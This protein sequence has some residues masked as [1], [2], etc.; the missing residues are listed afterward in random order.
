MENLNIN[1][2]ISNPGAER[3]ILSNCMNDSNILIECQSEGLTPKHFAIEANKIIYN[4]IVFLYTKGATIDALSILNIIKDEKTKAIVEQMGGIEYIMLLQ[5]SPRTYN[6]KMFIQDII[7]TYTRRKIYEMC[8]TIQHDVIKDT[9]NETDTVIGAI[10]QQIM[11]LTLDTNKINDGY[12]MGDKL[13]ERLNKASSN[14][15]AIPGLAVGW[16]QYDKLTGGAIPGD[17]I[18]ICAESKTGKSVTMLNWARHIAIEQ[19]LPILWIDSEQSSEEEE[20]RLVSGISQVHESELKSGMFTQDT[21]YGTAKDKIQR[22]NMAKR[23]LHD[24]QFHHIFMPDFTLEKI[25]AVTRKFHL[26]YGIVA[27]FFDYIKLTQTLINQNRNMRDDLILTA[28][29][30]GLKAL[31]GVLEIPIFTACQENRT[32]YG[33]TDKTAKNIGGSIGILQLA[34]KLLFLRN[35]TDA[36]LAQEGV[37]AGNQKLLIKYQRHGASGDIE[38]N[39]HYDKPKLTQ[40]EV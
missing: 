16:P 19:G 32:G 14:P 3:V 8:T 21:E 10:N 31:G 5:Q 35:K 30:D 18:I 26:K 25:T 34:T 27:L 2:L 28:F 11:N 37:R 24:A 17:L 1:E 29:V 22:V 36:E 40:Y 4:A 12:K 20:Y 7:N 13:Q 15:T 23:L 9:N 6:I 33:E 39:I 38:L